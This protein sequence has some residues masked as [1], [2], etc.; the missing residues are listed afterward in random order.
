MVWLE[1]KLVTSE[2]RVLLVTSLLVTWGP[3][4][5]SK[6]PLQL[7]PQ[8]QLQPRE[9]GRANV[10]C[11]QR[12]SPEVTPNVLIGHARPQGKSESVVYI[13]G[14]HEPS[15]R[16][17]VVHAG[18]ERQILRTAGCLYCPVI[19]TSLICTGTAVLVET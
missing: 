10:V 16:V 17:G 5:S 11:L 3:L 7:Q 1:Q 18:R 14:G 12:R 6:W 2:T 19:G 15:W 13:L 8:E 9:G 4:Q